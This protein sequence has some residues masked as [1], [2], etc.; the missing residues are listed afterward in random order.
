MDEAKVR[1]FIKTKRRMYTP[2]EV[3]F[4]NCAEVGSDRTA[5]V[6]CMYCFG[7]VL[8]PSSASAF[9]PAAINSTL[10][11]WRREGFWESPLALSRRAPTRPDVAGLL[12]VN[13]SQSLRPHEAHP[14]E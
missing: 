6:A 11:G 5:G 8:L 4:H 7:L 2:T 10:A 3:S 14:A 13:I 1:D 12:G 9:G